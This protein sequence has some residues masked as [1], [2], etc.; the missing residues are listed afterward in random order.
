MEQAY[1]NFIENV[2]ELELLL[3]QID[4]LS[5]IPRFL[6]VKGA[7]SKSI[8]V[9]SCGFFEGFL[10]EV[11]SEFIEEINKLNVPRKYVGGKLWENNRRKTLEVL[12]LIE[13]RKLDSSYSEVVKAYHTSFNKNKRKNKPLLVKESFSL[14]KHNPS[15]DTIKAM[16]NNVGIKIFDDKYIKPRFASIGQVKIT[17]SSYIS[18]RHSFAHGDSKGIIIPSL[19][20]VENYI[21]F[22]KDFT[23]VLSNALKEEISKIEIKYYSDCFS[24]F[25]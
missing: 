6:K 5:N 10:K 3:K 20:D 19:G 23:Y 18:L 22:L 21:Y 14:T 17:L 15:E 4:K 12:K 13:E 25:T 7:A 9:V 16:F 24:W 1:N 2:G 11:F 8:I